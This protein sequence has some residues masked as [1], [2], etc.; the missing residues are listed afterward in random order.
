MCAI[1]HTVRLMRWKECAEAG[2]RIVSC[3]QICSGEYPESV[4]RRAQEVD[5]KCAAGGETAVLLLDDTKFNVP[6]MQDHCCPRPCYR[7]SSTS[8]ARC[9]SISSWS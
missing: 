2:V 6:E 1:E 8:H 9:P 7:S 5:S 4:K 3:S